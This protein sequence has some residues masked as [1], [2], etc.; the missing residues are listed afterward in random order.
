ML[1]HPTWCL[2]KTF[3]PACWGGVVKK[4][5]SFVSGPRVL[6]SQWWVGPLP[7]LG[8]LQQSRRQAI[9]PAWEGDMDGGYDKHVD[10]AEDED[11]LAQRRLH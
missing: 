5:V 4:V 7:R 3:V 1:G 6:R 10:A 2:P 11:G 9:F 8:V